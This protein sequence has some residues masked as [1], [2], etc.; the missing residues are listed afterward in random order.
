MKRYLIYIL[1][2]YAGLAFRTFLATLAGEGYH[3]NGLDILNAVIFLLISALI[4]KQ[5]RAYREQEAERQNLA[6]SNTKQ[7]E[8]QD[9]ALADK[10][11]KAA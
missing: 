11:K 8:R 6:Q 2:A 4:V 7:E 9:A 10:E 3:M 1:S 5:V